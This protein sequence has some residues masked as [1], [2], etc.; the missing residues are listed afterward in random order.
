MAKVMTLD[1]RID[2]C[3]RLSRTLDSFDG[4]DF[5]AFDAEGAWFRSDTRQSPVDTMS[6]TFKVGDVRVPMAVDV[7]ADGSGTFT[8][9]F[10]ASY[11]TR[12]FGVD[13]PAGEVCERIATLAFYT[14]RY[15]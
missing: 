9:Y 7:Y 3:V 11:S 12:E 1:E 14:A 5:G 2:R 10:G 15:V 13:E 6:F 8:A 4:V